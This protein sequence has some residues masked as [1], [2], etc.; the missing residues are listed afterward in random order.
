M[1]KLT[2]V[3][4]FFLGRISL[5][6]NGI[7]DEMG[8]DDIEKLL[9]NGAN[10]SE[11]FKKRIKNSLT[12]AYA[13]DFDNFKTKIV[14]EDPTSLW[15]ESVKRLYS[16]KENLL[17]DIVNEWYSKYKKPGFF[18]MIKGLFKK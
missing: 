17:C 15:D 1:G 13:K 6:L 16:K 2:A 11:E 8:K 18:D 7:G 14:T 5:G 10:C 4:K 12:F 3:E 9:S